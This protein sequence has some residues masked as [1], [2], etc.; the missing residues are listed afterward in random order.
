[1]KSNIQNLVGKKAERRSPSGQQQGAIVTLSIG[2]LAQRL[3]LYPDPGSVYIVFGAAT[4]QIVNRHISPTIAL[5]GLGDGI[6]RGSDLSIL[7][8]TSFVGW[9]RSNDTPI[10]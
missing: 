5:C 4:K 10:L 1:M 9:T 6:M 7:A 3:A 2:P 8:M